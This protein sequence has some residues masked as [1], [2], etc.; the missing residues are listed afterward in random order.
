MKLYVLGLL[1]NSNLDKII[2]L[3]KAH[4]KGPRHLWGKLNALGGKVE[5][6]ELPIDAIRREVYEEAG[7]E[8]NDWIQFA[9]LSD[10]DQT[11][12]IYC[13]YHYSDEIYKF[14]QKEI[15]KP[16]IYRLYS[17]DYNEIGPILY[18]YYR[19]YPYLPNLDWLLSMALNRIRNLDSARHF[20]IVEDGVD[21]DKN[22]ENKI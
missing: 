4:G 3:Q 5:P 10:K 19:K 8:I 17:E 16:A 18:E 2:L 7:L 12:K 15:E 13:F 11:F 6:G 21:Y 9:T 20:D 1:F 14:Q 22:S